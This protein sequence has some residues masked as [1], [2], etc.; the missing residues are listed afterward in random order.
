MKSPQE[1]QDSVGQLTHND[2]E[3]LRFIV[4]QLNEFMEKPDIT[5]ES[6][7]DISNI[8]SEIT[9]IREIMLTR[10][11]YLFKRGYVLN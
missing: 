3:S 2:L 10:L 8:A 11:I 7:R 5:E 9:S 1:I 4:K 6:F